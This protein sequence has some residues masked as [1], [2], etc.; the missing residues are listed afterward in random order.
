MVPRALQLA[1][2]KHYRA[3]QCDDKSP[4]AAWLAAARAAIDAVASQES[5]PQQTLFP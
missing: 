3:G 1:V 5:K 4:S 2:W